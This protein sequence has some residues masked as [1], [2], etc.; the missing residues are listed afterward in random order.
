MVGNLALFGAKEPPQYVGMATE[1]RFI[2]KI[3]LFL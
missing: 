1:I 3:I 2:G